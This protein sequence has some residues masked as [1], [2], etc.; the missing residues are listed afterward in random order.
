MSFGEVKWGKRLQERFKTFSGLL[1]LLLYLAGNVQVESFH[2]VFHSLEKALHSTEQEK[3]P[4]HRAIYHEIKKEG[5]DHK[6]HLT[7]IKKCPLCHVI[8]FGDQ[9][10]DI[11]QHFLSVEFPTSFNVVSISFLWS[12]SFYNLPS[13]APPFA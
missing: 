8:P 2:R 6:T 3:D 10:A 12:D 11:R 1:L 5:C 13:R 7:G 4:C 9:H